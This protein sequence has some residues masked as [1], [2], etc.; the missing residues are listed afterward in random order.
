MALIPRSLRLPP[1]YRGRTLRWFS[2]KAPGAKACRLMAEDAWRRWVAGRGRRAISAGR[3]EGRRYLTAIP[4]HFC[5]IGHSWTEWNTA[6]QW[7]HRLGL[8]FVNLR[9]PEPWASF[10][11]FAAAA[12]TWKQVMQTERPLIVRLPSVAWGVGI[13]SCSLIEPVVDAIRSPRNLLFVL[14]D[15]QNSRDQ[16][17]FV[18]QQRADFVAHGGWRHLPDHR[19]PGRLNVAVHI[20]RGDV[21]TM[22]SADQGNWRIRFV[23]LDWFARA[24]AMIV[25]AHPG[26]RPLF[27]VYSQGQPEDFA[28]LGGTFDLRLHLDSGDQESLFNM[29]RADILVMSPSTFSFLAAIL[30]EGHKI[31]RIPWWHHLP[32][33]GDW[34]LL[35]ADPDPSVT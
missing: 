2:D 31:A 12:P 33:A 1:P 22:K 14:A 5:G 23:S 25:A 13:D 9:L 28:D 4:A 35:P 34:T 19:E 30:N 20:R 10:L 26:A 11:G 17:D 27:H 32:E 24:M 6:Y 3:R 29:S 15:G 18:A 21:A 7:A 8:E 16:T